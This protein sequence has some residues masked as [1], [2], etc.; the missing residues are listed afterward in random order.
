[1]N[2]AIYAVVLTALQGVTTNAGDFT[3]HERLDPIDD[4]LLVGVVAE[5]PEA[6]LSIACDHS[7]SRTVYVTLDTRD[8]L[9]PLASSLFRELRTFQY[10]VDRG[11]VHRASAEYTHIDRAF[12]DG[13]EGRAF[14]QR[15]ADSERVVIRVD[16]TRGPIDVTYDTTGLRP[17][18][19]RV[20]ERCGDRRL[21]NRLGEDA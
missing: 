14:A 21:I 19:E 9:A 13:A 15:L 3:Y 7:R 17:L 5:Q 12:L 10:R 18:I 20:A 6:K 8:V 4:A 11:S 1:M 2:T 16:G